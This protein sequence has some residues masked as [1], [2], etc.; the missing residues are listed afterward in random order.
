M[1]GVFICTPQFAH[2]PVAEE[3]L[4]AGLDV[5]V[6]KPLAHTLAEANSMVVAH[7]KRPNA[8]VGVGYMKS[9]EGIYQEVHRL[10]PQNAL[11]TLRTFD[12][13]CYLSQVLAKKTKGWIYNRNLSGGGMVINS[14]CH[15]LHALHRWFG[16]ARALKATCKSV[17]STDVEDEAVVDLE[18]KAIAGRLQTSWSV[19]GYDVETSSIRIEGET[20]TLEMKRPCPSHQCESP[21]ARG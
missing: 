17:H 19:P 21:V 9:H 7:R 4:E 13:H 12:A 15:F 1:K 5:F 6:E 3:C 18:Y 2:R 8:V 11:G 20:G 10:L 16:P 14:T